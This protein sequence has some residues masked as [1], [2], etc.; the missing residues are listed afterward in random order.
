MRRELGN[1]RCVCARAHLVC[2]TVA[3]GQG[4]GGAVRNHASEHLCHGTNRAGP[5]QLNVVLFQTNMRKFQ[6]TVFAVATL[7]LLAAAGC[8]GKQVGTELRNAGM[9]ALLFDV[10]CIQLWP[11]PKRA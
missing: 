8:L 2:I 11:P 4:V 6:I 9:A 10:V 1:T 3:A 5:G 7:A